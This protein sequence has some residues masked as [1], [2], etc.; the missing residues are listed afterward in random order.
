LVVA[1]AL[2]ALEGVVLLL[3]AVAELADLTEGRRSM[4][5][6]IAL[7]FA[8][9]GTVLVV[10]GAGLWRC[11][12]WARGPGLLTQL[13]ALGLAWNI[14]EESGLGTTVLAVTAVVAVL[15][16]IHPDSIEA[17]VGAPGP[18]EEGADEQA[19]PGRRSD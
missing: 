4:G 9:Y 8:G 19:D 7:F 16:M 10:A 2:V 17:L 3:L 13:I 14:R 5:A 15:A 12:T 11:A 18:D 1:A 6:S